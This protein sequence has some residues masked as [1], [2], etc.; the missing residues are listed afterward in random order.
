MLKKAAA[1]ARVP[2]KS[3][4]KSAT[5]IH[6]NC[7]NY[8]IRLLAPFFRQNKSTFKIKHRRQERLFFS[9]NFILR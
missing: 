2:R 4:S 8:G 5:K 3:R 6:D 1:Y 9:R 7:R